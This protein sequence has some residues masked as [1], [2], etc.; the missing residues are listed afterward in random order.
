MGNKHAAQNKQNLLFQSAFYED[1]QN[2]D[3]TKYLEKYSIQE[4]K[5]QEKDHY[6]E[7]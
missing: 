5:I 2:K 6:F 4:K 3:N 7:S 1:Y